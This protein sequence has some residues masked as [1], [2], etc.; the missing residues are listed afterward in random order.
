MPS[1]LR[2]C[3]EAGVVLAGTS[4]GSLCWSE[5]GPTDSHGDDLAGPAAQR[6]TRPTLRR[7]SPSERSWSWASPSWR[8]SASRCSCCAGL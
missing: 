5:R 8:S 7:W 6:R 3:W 2:R 4:A 1:V